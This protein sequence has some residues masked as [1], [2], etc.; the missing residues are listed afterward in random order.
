MGPAEERHFTGRPSRAARAAWEAAARAQG[1]RRV[2]DAPEGR[3]DRGS[4]DLTGAERPAWGEATEVHPVPPSAP[5]YRSQVS[6][7]PAFMAV[8]ALVAT[9]V[10]PGTF[11]R[12]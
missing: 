4:S 10:V 8:G 7:A 5:G 9:L 2:L 6:G 12:R 11:E 1:A 3:V